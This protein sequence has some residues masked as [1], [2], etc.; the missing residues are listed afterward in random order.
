MIFNLINKYWDS[1]VT[2]TTTSDDPDASITLEIAGVDY[3]VSELE[4]ELGNI[5]SGIYG[6][7][8]DIS[9]TTNLDLDYALKQ[10]PSFKVLSTEPKLT[11]RVIEDEVTT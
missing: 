7:T 3:D 8:F 5:T 10:V 2:I 4:R 6:H 9:D 11:P 1:T